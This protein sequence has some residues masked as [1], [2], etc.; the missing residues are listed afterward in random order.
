MII[1]YCLF[2][3]FQDILPS[4]RVIVDRQC[5]CCGFL[6]VVKHGFYP[7]FLEDGTF[8]TSSGAVERV[9][10]WLCKECRKTMSTP[11][12]LVV[13]YK[14]FDAM[15]IGRS[16]YLYFYMDLSLEKVQVELNGPS[17]S[18]IRNW[19]RQFRGR[20]VAGLKEFSERFSMDVSKA[21]G[22]CAI[23]V[24]S[25]LVRYSESLEEGL[26]DCGE[27]VIV[28]V[29]QLLLGRFPRLSLFRSD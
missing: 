14:H 27:N 26:G 21:Y 23:E 10:R 15:V 22:D 19:V 3:V 28:C 2:S 16:L 11:R 29:Q 7:R 5:F 25:M 20:A 8:S 6:G 18:T 4:H 1:P 17:F 24:F 13:A 12:S 9:Q